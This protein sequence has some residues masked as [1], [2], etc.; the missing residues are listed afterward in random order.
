M[1]GLTQ[2]AGILLSSPLVS[3]LF[4]H[5]ETNAKCCIQRRTPTLTHCTWSTHLNMP[6]WLAVICLILSIR[7][8]K[9]Y[10]NDLHQAPAN[11]LSLALL[12]KQYN[13]TERTLARLSQKEV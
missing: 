8:C 10:L 7:H 13:M 4:E 12:A 6:N 3:A 11:H 2:Q 1:S 9:P 5:L